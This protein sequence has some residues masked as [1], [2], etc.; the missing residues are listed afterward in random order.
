MSHEVTRNTTVSAERNLSPMSS[1]NDDNSCK[2]ARI[3][4]L[5]FVFL[6][7]FGIGAPVLGVAILLLGKI[8]WI[9]YNAG[10]VVPEVKFYLSQASH[11][12]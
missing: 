11:H 10:A 1:D 2:C 9:V 3:C 12:R 8:F 5:C 7:F 6:T 4:L